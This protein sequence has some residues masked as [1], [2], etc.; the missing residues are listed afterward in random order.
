MA[1][2]SIFEF[3]NSPDREPALTIRESGTCY[4]TKKMAGVN[5]TIRV[6]I[7][8]ESKKI[9]LQTGS[10]LERKLVGRVGVCFSVPKSLCRS[11]VTPGEKK[12]KIPMIYHDDGWWY[13]EINLVNND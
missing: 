11:L 13:G 7:D 12:L 3:S 10:D 6:E 9:R 4:I 5:K 1:F 2:V 8:F